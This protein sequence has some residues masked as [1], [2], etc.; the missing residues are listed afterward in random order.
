MSTRDS[1]AL[2]FTS[3]TK[4]I[5]KGSDLFAATTFDQLVA[6]SIEASEITVDGDNVSLEGHTHS[7]GDVTGLSE[8]LSGITST[9]ISKSIV[10]ANTVSASSGAFSN[11]LT[12]S[13]SNVSLEG[14]T[15]SAADISDISAYATQSWVTQQI[16]SAIGDVLAS[17]F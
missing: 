11:G 13:G 2:Y 9:S 17:T 4:R 12:V 16:Q 6:D 5:Y 14:H 10:V 7:F 3:D 1:G 15:H 8:A